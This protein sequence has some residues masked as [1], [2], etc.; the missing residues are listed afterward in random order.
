[1]NEPTNVRFHKIGTKSVTFKTKIENVEGALEL[2][3]EVGFRP[4][5]IEFEQ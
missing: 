5:V 2:L 3:T 4:V 1:V